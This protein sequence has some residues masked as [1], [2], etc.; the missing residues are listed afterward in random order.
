MH[1]HNQNFDISNWYNN[2]RQT[3]KRSFISRII[4]NACLASFFIE[5][6]ISESCQNKLSISFRNDHGYATLF[7]NWL[8]IC[9]IC[10]L[11]AYDD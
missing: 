6:K 5:K 1:Q 3:V 11:I 10:L 4:V 2:K 8:S 7:F 9:F